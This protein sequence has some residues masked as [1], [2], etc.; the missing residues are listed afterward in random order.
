MFQ[1][2]HIYEHTAGVIDSDFV[3]KLPV[4]AHLLRRKFPLKE[5]DVSKFIVLMRK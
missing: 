5:D 4:Y 1:A 3:K 2:K